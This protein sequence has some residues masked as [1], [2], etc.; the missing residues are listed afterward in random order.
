VTRV[1]AGGLT[2]FGYESAD[3]TYAADSDPAFVLTEVDGIR[4]YSWA[5]VN[6]DSKAFT[7]STGWVAQVTTHGQF[8][9]TSSQDIQPAEAA[10]GEAE[11]ELFTNRDSVYVEVEQQGA[12]ARLEPGAVLTWSVRWKLRP[13]P[14]GESFFT[15]GSADLVA[16][17]SKVLAE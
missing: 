7:D 11:V 4:W 12:L 15:P 17:A 8:F 6:H 2:F 10:P 9:L 1:A 13:T 3:V 14:T 16:L 5:T